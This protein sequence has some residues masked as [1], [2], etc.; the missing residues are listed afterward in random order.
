MI[1]SLNVSK[2]I[3]PACCVV[4]LSTS[5]AKAEDIDATTETL[6]NRP[7]CANEYLEEIVAENQSQLLCAQD[8]VF[9]LQEENYNLLTD[10]RNA[11]R[12]LSDIIVEK[13]D[14]E[15]EIIQKKLVIDDLKKVV[16][17][18]HLKTES[19]KIIELQTKIAN[20]KAERTKRKTK[21][22]NEIKK[23]EEDHK[24][25]VMKLQNKFNSELKDLKITQAKRLAE[26]KTKLISQ[27]IKEKKELK[28]TF[29]KKLSKQQEKILILVKE[30]KKY[31]KE[32]K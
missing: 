11:E 22:K 2:I 10:L 1:L 20:L 30:N 31:K 28:N 24:L 27:N 18:Y 29:D 3:I 23:H 8:E 17:S 12:S 4:L 14:L 16:E 26:V 9:K 25:Q 19:D 21:E 7:I 13:K 6:E 15:M 32:L 5:F